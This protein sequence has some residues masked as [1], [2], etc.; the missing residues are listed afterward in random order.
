MAIDKLRIDILQ[1]VN[2]EP[3]LQRGAETLTLAEETAI[4]N[5]V[6]DIFQRFA[7]TTFVQEDWDAIQGGIASSS[8]ESK[9]E[10]FKECFVGTGARLVIQIAKFFARQNAATTAHNVQ[11]FGI[12]D[13][14]SLVEIAKL[15]AEQNG[16][17]TAKNITNFGIRDRSVLFDLGVYCFSHIPGVFRSKASAIGMEFV[18]FPPEFLEKLQYA[19]QMIH[20]SEFISLVSQELGNGWKFLTDYADMDVHKE[21]VRSLFFS[22][23]MMDKKNVLASEAIRD[24]VHALL[25]FRV[26][27]LK[28]YLSE[29]LAKIIANDKSRDFEAFIHSVQIP[30]KYQ[31][32]RIAHVFLLAVFN[33]VNDERLRLQMVNDFLTHLRNRDSFLP[34]ASKTGALIEFLRLVSDRA[35][36]GMEPIWNQF[37][38][39]SRGSAQF[40][41]HLFLA[42]AAICLGIDISQMTADQIE[43]LVYQHMHFPEGFAEKF[44]ALR[45]PQTLFMFFRRINQLGKEREQILKAWSTFILEITDGSFSRNRYDQSP[46]LNKMAQEYCSEHGEG[47]WSAIIDQWK[48]G[49]K[50]TIEDFVSSHESLSKARTF[51]WKPIFR[52]I[53]SMGVLQSQDMPLL[54]A[55]LDS[56]SV[57]DQIERILKNREPFTQ[58]QV[59]D[60]LCARLV[61]QGVLDSQL[62]QEALTLAPSQGKI[63]KF[64]RTFLQLFAPSTEFT[65]FTVENTDDC[66]DLFLCSTELPTCMSIDSPACARPLL[67][68]VMDGKNRMIAIK[69]THGRIVA[70]S[71][72]KLLWDGTQKKP[73]LLMEPSFPYMSVK[74]HIFNRIIEQLARDRAASL[75]VEFVD[76]MAYAGTKTDRILQSYTNRTGF[77][78]EDG[79]G[80]VVSVAI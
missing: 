34:I 4:Q 10:I 43:P 40:S 69:D 26:P 80:L 68:Y 79:A 71:M 37:V 27:F 52:N 36:E 74:E 13:P 15:C 25:D 46:H 32:N 19:Y 41:Q 76:L 5:A 57:T 8:F 78:H 58:K 73:V 30:K 54:H 65:G 11:V 51:D 29:A 45:S 60:A 38:I 59:F 64:F 3:L 28:P 12:Q 47:S 42:Q 77:E 48:S 75:G 56:Q 72:I 70:R 55:S 53:L 6:S 21:I 35:K 24:T 49:Q 20:A 18:D 61:Q 31:K 23:I 33:E 9:R 2:H 14:T 66:W 67:G 16:T 44:E 1:F 39:Y 7:R 50:H 62:E 22:C 17:E 63:R